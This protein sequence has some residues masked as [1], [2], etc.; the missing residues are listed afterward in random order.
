MLNVTKAVCLHEQHQKANKLW[1]RQK[2]TRRS[3]Y[4]SVAFFITGYY[5][6]NF[7]YEVAMLVSFFGAPTWRPLLIKFVQNVKKILLSIT[8]A[9]HK[10]LKMLFTKLKS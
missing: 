4:S 3:N 10:H 1:T 8:L 2:E 9:Y 6:I 7:L 5:E